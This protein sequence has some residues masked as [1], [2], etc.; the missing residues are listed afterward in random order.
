M[1]VADSSLRR[2]PDVL[3]LA[4]LGY[5]HRIWADLAA[6][7]GPDP[8]DPAR[9][10]LVAAGWAAGRAVHAALDGQA[11]G[12]VLFQPAPDYLPP[13]ARPEVSLEEM[14]AAAAPWAGLIDAAQETDAVRR[15]E[16]VVATWR[17]IY[18]PHLAAPDID[19]ACQVISAHVD[20]VL[21]TAA[22]SAAAAMAGGPMP[23]LGP[24]WVDRL[25]ELTVPVTVMTSRR[26][27]RTGQ[28][29]AGRIPDGRFVVADAETDLVWLEDRGS[30]TTAITDLLRLV[31]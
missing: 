14:L 1:R 15:T 13:E 26:A 30:A 27:S 17:D 22:E 28:A 24:P 11:A 25:A 2:V 6:G 8:A 19:L 10:V 5:D 23:Q 20:E 18:G 16:L 21:A 7:F 12:L 4:D 31:A 29:L 3:F 9:T